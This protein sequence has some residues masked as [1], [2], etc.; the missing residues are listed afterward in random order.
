MPRYGLRPR[1]LAGTIVVAAG[2]VAAT[3]WL[4]VQ[5]TTTSI[6]Q[7]EDSVRQAYPLVYDG[8]VDYAATHTG[9]S[10]I[11]PVLAD[12]AQQWAVRIVVTPVGGRPIESSPAAAGIDR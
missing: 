9:W 4:S 3:A 11:G 2:A 10:T 6:A 12:M 5:G 8:I 1:L 7:Q